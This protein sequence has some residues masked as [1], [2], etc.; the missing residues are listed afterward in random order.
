MLGQCA[1]LAVRPGDGLNLQAWSRPVHLSCLWSSLPSSLQ[2]LLPVLALHSQNLIHL[3][4]VWSPGGRI[5]NIPIVNNICQV[6]FEEI[7]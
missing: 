1:V 3:T 7:L 2:D 4:P 5:L 6:E